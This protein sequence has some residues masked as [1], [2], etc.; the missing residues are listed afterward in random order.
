M[1]GP[2]LRTS[3]GL[4]AVDAVEVGL[5]VA[6]FAVAGFAVVDFAVAGFSAV[7]APTRVAHLAWQS[8]C[9]RDQS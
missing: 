2:N 3:A 8:R 4:G 5:A 9:R 6:G 7:S 1:N